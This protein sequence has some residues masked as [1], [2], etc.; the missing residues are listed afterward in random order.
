M[1]D[2]QISQHSAD[3]LRAHLAPLRQLPRGHSA[4]V[5]PEAIAHLL[6]ALGHG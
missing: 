4:W 1:G 3:S 2:D 5:E 6:L